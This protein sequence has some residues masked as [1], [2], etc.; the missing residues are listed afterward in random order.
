M[1]A[2]TFVI[3][4]AL[5]SMTSTWAVASEKPDTTYMASL[6]MAAEKSKGLLPDLLR[7]N[8]QLDETTLYEVQKK[9]VA[10]RTE[11]GEK[12]TGYKGGFV[13]KASVGGVLFSHG[14]LSGS[15]TIKRGDFRSLLVEAEMAFRFC[16]PVIQPLADV[17]AL[18]RVV[19]K[20][21]AAIELPDVALPDMG[22]LRKNFPHL[23]KLLIPTN[24]AAAYV[25]LGPERDPGTIDLNRLTVKVSH[26]GEEIGSRDGSTAQ[27]DLWQN[28]LWVVNDFVLK[29]SYTIDSGH[30]I[31]PGNLTGLHPGKPGDYR[32]DYGDLGMIN[33][34]VAPSQ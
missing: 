26:N 34:K 19:C 15:P 24:V 2:K 10:L 31:I 21:H 14:L 22:A 4:L 18:R 9:Y 11:Q 20:V 23:R 17:A 6:L 29:H 27:G 3:V 33:F 8:P 5:I 32:A 13:P 16:E 30:I 25:L 28:V 12:I 1:Q 7:I